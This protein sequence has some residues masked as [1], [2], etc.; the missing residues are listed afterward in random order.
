VVR[1][2][3]AQGC[4]LAFAGIVIGGAGAMGITRL[5][6]SLLYNVTPSDPVSFVGTALVL[7]VVTILAGAVP[8][9]RATTVDPI[10]ALRV[11]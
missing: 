10:V 5:V 3:L 2:V 7:T 1:L 9:F 8:A 6:R 11:D 4:R